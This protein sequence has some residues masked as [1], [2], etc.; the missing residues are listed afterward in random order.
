[1]LWIRC[2]TWVVTI[3]AGF[4]QAWSLRFSLSPDANAYLSIA[5]AYLRGDYANAINAYFSPMYSWLIA[6]VLGIF[7]PSG[8][9]ETTSLHLL[10]FAGL[11]IALYCFEFFFVGFLVFLE[12]SSQSQDEPPL[13]EAS[14]WLLGYGLF[15]STMLFLLTLEP[16][17]PDMWVCVVSYLAVGILLRIALHPRKWIYFVALGFVLGLAYLTKSF[18]FPLSFVF[19]GAAWFTG[20][21]LRKNFTRVLVALVVFVLVAGPFVYAISKSKHRFTFGDAGKITYAIVMNPIPAAAFLHWDSNSGIPKHPPRQIFSSPRVFESAA[22]IKGT[23]PLTDLSYWMEG[24]TPHFTLRGQMRILR[25]SVGTFF[26]MFLTQV[27]FAAGFFVL[28]ICQER[29]R[30]CIAAIARLW[31]LWLPPAVACLAYSIVLVENRYVAPFLVFL[32]IAAFAGA[33]R[34]PS[35]LSR[36]VATAVL[37]GI[38]CVTGIKTAKYFTT[39]LFALQ[40]QRNVYWDVAQNLSKIG[41]KPGDKFALIGSTEGVHWA[42]LAGVQIVSVLPLG[43]DEVFWNADR[44]TQERVFAAFAS[45]GSRLVVVKDPPPGSAR[46]NWRQ[47]GNTP[48]YTHL[49]P[50]NP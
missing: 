21:T 33:V 17:T 31:P 39:D 45:T 19:L 44:A 8:Y 23:F 9:W 6:A 41:V 46:E 10:N 38:L 29:S 47:L 2:L 27:E 11:L 12:H 28:L 34:V 40:H 7:H 13:N 4:V 26:V 1:L 5:S 3:L 32:W 20:G 25:Q 15:F 50:G 43:D 14:W 48:Y 35:V 30:E 36:R 16:T 42:R 22:P 24:A 37:L 18:F 49:L